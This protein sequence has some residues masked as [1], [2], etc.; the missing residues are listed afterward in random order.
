MFERRT[1]RDD[2]GLEG[3]LR[4]RLQHLARQR[5]GIGGKITRGGFETITSRFQK[6]R[7][8][9]RIESTLPDHVVSS[10]AN[11]I[12][13]GDRRR[14][15][16]REDREPV[17]KHRRMN[18][19]GGPTTR[20]QTLPGCKEDVDFV[21]RRRTLPPIM[22]VGKAIHAG[23]RRTDRQK[24]DVAVLGEQ[25]PGGRTVQNQLIGPDPVDDE[26]DGGPQPPRFDETGAAGQQ[27]AARQDG[28]HGRQ[29]TTARRD[30][31]LP[32]ARQ[33]PGNALP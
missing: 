12:T 31:L 26:I 30:R 15:G 22:I 33:V 6:D 16:T 5:R 19:S 11:P 13:G 4:G 29:N 24:I 25:A 3:T 7:C 17:G 27:L 8:A 18:G 28:A 14:P 10:G 23:F 1:V 32:P 9:M 21:T 20:L 2:Q